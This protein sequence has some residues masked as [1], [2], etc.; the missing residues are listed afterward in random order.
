MQHIYIPRSH[1]KNTRGKTARL[2]FYFVFSSCAFAEEKF[3]CVVFVCLLLLAA[4]LNI[5]ANP[6]WITAAGGTI[7]RDRAGNVIAI[8]LRASWV[9]DA[10]LP[11]LAA[12]PHLAQLDLS[13]TR[14]TD[15]GLQ[16]LKNAPA[17]TELNLYYAEQ[18]TDEG[19]AAIKGWKR[20][21]R[22]EDEGV[23]ERRVAVLNRHKTGLPVTV[24]VR[25]RKSVV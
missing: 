5:H 22:L 8:D 14:I 1:T 16:Q 3:R 12:L 18:V 9:T 11:Q 10:D 21:K 7:T 19:M 20:L 15:H 24:F 2:G 4:P 13:H 23:I 17:I 6:D 25:D